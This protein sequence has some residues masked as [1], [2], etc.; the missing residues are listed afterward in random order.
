MTP[1]QL[2]LKVNSLAYR[3][4]LAETIPKLEIE[5]MTY[6]LS[7]GKQDIVISGYRISLS[8]GNNLKLTE[9]ATINSD[10]LRLELERIEKKP[11]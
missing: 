7:N 3:K 2:A 10:Q 4:K 8:D 11:C 9:R 6:L 5:I 1:R